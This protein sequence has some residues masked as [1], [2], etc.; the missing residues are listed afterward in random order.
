MIS[1]SEMA[2]RRV[3]RAKINEFVRA[4]MEP[5]HTSAYIIGH[6]LDAA[7]QDFFTESSGSDY[8]HSGFLLECFRQ[9]FTSVEWNGH[10]ILRY[11]PI[12]DS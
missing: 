4:N 10:T 2:K 1:D 8:G 5:C 6:Q 9:A 3:V 11:P 12:T 7:I